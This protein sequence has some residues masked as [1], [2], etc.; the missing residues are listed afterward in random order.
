M[1]VDGTTDQSAV[2]WDRLRAW[3]DEQEAWEREHKRPAPLTQ[4]QRTA[5][6][7]LL[8]PVTEPDIGDRDYV[9]ELCR[10]S[11]SASHLLRDALT[12]EPEY[13]QAKHVD[14][15]TFEYE[16][17]SKNAVHPLRWRCACK[18]PLCGGVFPQAGHGYAAGEEPPSF[19]SKKV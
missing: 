11:Y 8:P 12:S 15:P 4:A 2:P 1:A 18:F 10:E 17:V 13:A 19:S 16:S 9:S 14:L 3:I 6:A 5:I 7:S